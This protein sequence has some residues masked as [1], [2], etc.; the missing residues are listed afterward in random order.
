VPAE[1]AR[2]P[3]RNADGSSQADDCKPFVGDVASGSSI[4]TVE[5]A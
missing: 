3:A 5:P 2:Q 1:S 4:R